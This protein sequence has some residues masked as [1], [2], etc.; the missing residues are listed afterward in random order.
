MIKVNDF[1]KRMAEVNKAFGDPTRLIIIKILILNLKQGVLGVDLA[2]K[3][4]ITA[5]AVS[6]HLKVLK[7]INVVTDER[8]GYRIY[9]RIN[10]EEFKKIKE[11]ENKLFELAFNNCDKCLKKECDK[12]KKI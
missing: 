10:L 9:Y 11:D 1:I 7:N 8:K 5:S 3:L 2:E 12:C 6:Q 4:E